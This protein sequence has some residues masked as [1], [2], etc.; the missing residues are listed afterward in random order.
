MYWFSADGVAVGDADDVAPG[1]VGDVVT[2]AVCADI[3]VPAMRPIMDKI[4]SKTRRYL[5]EASSF[6]LNTSLKPGINY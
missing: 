3:E 2:D 4:V 1:I 6:I 5:I